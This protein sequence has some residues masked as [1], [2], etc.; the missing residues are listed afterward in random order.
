MFLPGRIAVWLL[1]GACL[2]ASLHGQQ[3]Q[4]RYKVTGTVVNS[5]TGE[6]IARALVSGPGLKAPIFTDA[7]GKFEAD[8]VPGGR[9]YF[10][11]QRPGY[12]SQQNMP[13][14]ATRRSTLSI[15]ASHTTVE[16]KMIPAAQM[17]VRVV[18]ADGQ[19]VEGIGLQLLLQRMQDGLREWRQVNAANTDDTGT[20]SFIDLYPGSYLIRSYPK[21]LYS[22]GIDLVVDGQHYPDLYAGSFYPGVPD[23]A[24]AQKVKV[25]AGASLDVD[26]QV[27]LV[28]TYSIYGKISSPTAANISCVDE[29][30]NPTSAMGFANPR[31]STFQVSGVPAGLCTLQAAINDRQGRSSLAR[32]PITVTSEDVTGITLA[33]HDPIPEIP[34]VLNGLPPDVKNP[35]INLRVTSVERN[36]QAQITMRTAA[37]GTQHYV[38]Y[39]PVP[40][41]Y[42]L[43]ATGFGNMC[44]GTMEAGGVD[45]LNHDLDIDFDRVPPQIE[46]GLRSDCAALD[47]VVDGEEPGVLTPL[48]IAGGS[49]GLQMLSIVG[50][51]SLPGLIPG[52]Y[53]LYAFTDSAG[54]EYRKPEALSKLTGQ[55]ITLAPS[56][57]ASIHLKPQAPP[58]ETEP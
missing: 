32:L 34:F 6:P 43:T 11:A 48:L 38:L 39:R 23:R 22:D 7:S 13:G 54:F 4:N 29:E 19:P 33:L 49:G 16:I 42:R 21:R 9:I 40:G 25:E 14:G 8:N 20:A 17:R 18:D 35:P 37:D 53:T 58:P 3:N 2:A 51:V 57:K 45:L 30:G 44:V 47:V 31:S 36:R 26:M 55:Q 46:I 50:K 15:D 1:V 27:K 24:S 28:P 56:Q 10:D 52:D 12:F 41:H 5:V